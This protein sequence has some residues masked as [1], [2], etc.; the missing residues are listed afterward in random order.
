MVIEKLIVRKI[1]PSNSWTFMYAFTYSSDYFIYGHE[2]LIRYF[3]KCET[4]DEISQFEDTVHKLKSLKYFNAKSEKCVSKLSKIE[5]GSNVNDIIEIGTCLVFKDLGQNFKAKV[6]VDNEKKEVVF[7]LYN[8]GEFS[9]CLPYFTELPDAKEEERLK[10]KFEKF[11]K[12]KEES[13]QAKLV[14]IIFEQPKFFKR[15]IS[16]GYKFTI[17]DLHKYSDLIDWDEISE[18]NEIDWDINL[19]ETFIGNWNWENLCSNKKINWTTE[20]IE[21]FKS[22]ISWEGI[23]KNHFLNW[24]EI[25][26]RYQDNLDWDELSSNTSFPWTKE[27]IIK[28]QS[29]IEWSSLCSNPNV[30]FDIEILNKFEN[31]IDW[32]L[33]A[34]NT[35]KWW[36][37]KIIDKF[38][39][40]IRWRNLCVYGTFWTSELI[41]YFQNVIRINDGF[42]DLSE[43]SHIPWTE[44]LL[45]KYSSLLCWLSIAENAKLSWSSELMEKFKDK[46]RWNSLGENP[47]FP[48][49]IELV[50]KHLT[51]LKRSN[52]TCSLWSNVGL[53]QQE[54]FWIEHKDLLFPIFKGSG[55][56]HVIDA[57]N[58]DGMPVSINLLYELRKNLDWNRHFSFMLKRTGR[59][60]VFIPNISKSIFDL[61]LDTEH[62][63]K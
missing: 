43:N 35:G 22:Y 17:S 9:G 10:I 39:K 46:L 48:W 25:L 63:E 61:V 30:E 52:G 58:N 1:L 19:I 53:P 11:E 47:S 31:K 44:E 3:A 12:F 14:D 42:K 7:E 26:D 36:T 49:T 51:S 13:N 15:F 29:N 21:K 6:F 5:F 2:E 55:L 56:N 24:N 54:Q 50:E 62:F 4:N 37:K 28:F 20:K 41:D 34:T 33:I 23:S 45:D 32:N 38:K 57:S 60:N 16:Y 8:A 18:N 40:S 59:Y 27:N